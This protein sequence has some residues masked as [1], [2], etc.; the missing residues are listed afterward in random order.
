MSIALTGILVFL[1]LVPGFIYRRF[2][3]SEEFSKQYFTENFFIAFSSSFFPSLLLYL[4]LLFIVSIDGYKV[5]VEIL[6]NL[7]SNNEN[8]S[9]ALAKLES[10]FKEI[11]IF[12]LILYVLSALS[13]YVVRKTVRFYKLDRLSKFFRFQNTWHYIFSGEFFDFKRTD[14]ELSRNSV[15]DIE[16]IYVDALVQTLEGTIIYDGILISY[17]L[18]KTGG[19]DRIVLTQVQR[20]FMK[21]DQNKE[22]KEK[23][24][25]IPGHVFIL[26]FDKILNL[27]LTYYALE[28]TK[29][30]FNLVKID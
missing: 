19:L 30:G 24:Y 6:G 23:Y 10:T 22:T 29:K 2:Y 14:Y 28:F 20:R 26:P 15:E 17:D 9:K 3:Y 1:L 11:T 7:L 13:G 8:A 25:N 18:A 5:D 12:H 16:L 21:D 4:S 27:N